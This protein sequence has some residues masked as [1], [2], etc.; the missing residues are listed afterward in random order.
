MVEVSVIGCCSLSYHYAN[1]QIIEFKD[2]KNM[3]KK[4][5]NN[6]NYSRIKYTTIFN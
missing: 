6:N 2:K 5:L 1:M 3:N 4:L